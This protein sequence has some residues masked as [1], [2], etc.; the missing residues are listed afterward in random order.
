MKTAWLP[1]MGRKQLQPSQLLENRTCVHFGPGFITIAFSKRAHSVLP[2]TGILGGSGTGYWIG[3]GQ[4]SPVTTLLPLPTGCGVS[5]P[6]FDWAF[7]SA[8]ASAVASDFALFVAT[9]KLP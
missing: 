5:D 4:G 8:V 7:A 6:V 9:R 3:G 2:M 1:A